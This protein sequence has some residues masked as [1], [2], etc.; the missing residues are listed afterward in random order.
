MMRVAGLSRAVAAIVFLACLSPAR[1]DD[2]AP[3]AGSTA[4]IS[5]GGEVATPLRFDAAALQKM[6]HRAFDA[7][8]HGKTAHWD[9]VALAELLRAAGV[10]LGKQL[11]GRNLALYV[12]ITATDGYRVVYSLAELDPAMHDGDVILADRRDGHALDGK[13][14]PFRLVAR[15]D[16]R[17]ARWVRQ[18]SAIDVLAAPPP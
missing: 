15:D 4:T 14:G 3:R 5:I 8:E 18:V 13:E 11:R 17:P 9:G 10:P 7:S 12:R 2:P 6:P 16:K 1:A